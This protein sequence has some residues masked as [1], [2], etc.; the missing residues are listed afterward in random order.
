M[1]AR[2]PCGKEQGEGAELELGVGLHKTCA[3]LTVHS[4]TQRTC[5]PL[6]DPMCILNFL[7][8]ARWEWKVLRKVIFD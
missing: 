2:G 4:V 3:A 1:R 6:I 5:P 7:H 8:T